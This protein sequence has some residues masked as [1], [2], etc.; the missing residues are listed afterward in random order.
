MQGAVRGSDDIEDGEVA[1]A[2]QHP[3]RF[4]IKSGPVGDVH[5]DVLCPRDIERAGGERQGE[6]VP[7]LVG[8]L[9]VEA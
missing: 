5:G 9:S 6:G 3:E 1:A 4:G 7:E 2:T 8:D